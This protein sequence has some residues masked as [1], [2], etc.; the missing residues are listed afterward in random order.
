MYI[1]GKDK[2]QNVYIWQVQV[3]DYGI[4]YDLVPFLESIQSVMNP[5]LVY[6]PL[7][8]ILC[9]MYFSGHLELN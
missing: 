7:M 3:I 5:N 6:F 2:F 1:Y 4:D 9:E 8:Y